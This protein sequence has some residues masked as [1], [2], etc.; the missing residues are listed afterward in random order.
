MIAIPY[1][2]YMSELKSVLLPEPVYCEAVQCACHG[3][4]NTMIRTE[5][6]MAFY[7]DSSYCSDEC[8]EEAS[9]ASLDSA[10]EVDDF[11]NYEED[12]MNDIIDYVLDNDYDW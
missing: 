2:P 9:T 3:C 8:L 5:H 12:E 4:E 6:P 11:D 1:I 7:D 10:S